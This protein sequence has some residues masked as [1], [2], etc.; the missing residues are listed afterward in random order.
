MGGMG[1]D[2]SVGG[3]SGVGGNGGAVPDPKLCGNSQ[4]DPGEQC[5]D[6]NSI[7]GDGCD[8]DCFFSC[9]PADAS[10]CSD[11]NFCNGPETCNAQHQCQKSAGPAAD[12]TVCG[13]ANRCQGGVCVAAAAVCGDGLIERPQEDC[14]DG[15]T[16][17]GDGCDN[18]RFTCL[19]TDPARNCPTINPCQGNS[20]CNDGTHKCEPI[21][22]TALS[23]GASCGDGKACV[24][25][26]C[27]D[28]YC[29]NG[30]LD[31]GEECDDGNPFKAD[32]CEPNC[33]FSCV[34][35]DPM[36]NC[37]SK[38]ECIASGTCNTTTHKCTPLDPKPAGTACQTSENCVEG[39]CIQPVCGD[40]IKGPNEACDDGNG[41]NTDACTTQCLPVCKA[42]TVATDCMG[43]TPPP[44]RVISCNGGACGTKAD[45]TQNG[46][47]CSF[48]G[49]NGT[50]KDGACSN[51]TCGDHV[52]DPGEQCD[53]GNKV[54]GDGCDT[55]CLFS[56]A[57]DTDCDD[58]NPCNGVEKCTMVGDNKLCKAENP[59]ADGA[60]CAAGKICSGSICRASFCGDGYTDMKKGETCDPPNTLGCDSSCH[61]I[62]TCNITG[63]WA[64]KVAAKV[65]WTGAGLV[66]GMGEIDQ[67]ALMKVVQGNNDTAFTASI[68]PCGITIP[69]FHSIPNFG[70]E[71]YG[72]TFPSSAFDSPK[73]PTFA[74]N[75]KLGNLSPGASFEA[76]TSTIL[77]GLTIGSPASPSGQWP[78]SYM[79]LTAANGF[80][81]TDV[82]ND[83]SPGITA[84]VKTGTIPGTATPYKDIIWDIGNPPLQNPGRTGKLQIVIRQI[85]AENGTLDTCSQLSGTTSAAIDN[86]IVGCV[87]DDKSTTCKPDLLDFARPVYSTTSATFLAYRIGTDDSCGAVRTA[88]P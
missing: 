24:G 21:A 52:L 71:T 20:K 74:F 79:D 12:G 73:I 59:L 70:D 55:D 18:C 58:K 25:G 77:I 13:D 75:G 33:T 54:D 3:M 62:S 84:N 16:V 53:D 76:A 86:H 17:N 6:G 43:K 65:T 45:T 56:C 83:G 11:G 67:W 26:I 9:T 47:S 38:V 57:A 82:D 69:D 1:P 27:T 15:N 34:P 8:K 61:A 42:A 28:K 37:Q 63:N 51:G 68:K 66:D 36:R 22:G 31:A 80:T 23:E 41:S 72:I 30:K 35:T 88:V 64:M 60:D 87:A 85:A 32:G 46:A 39:N 81:V 14:E 29:G 49:Q 4:M 40:G 78:G 2:A 44:C 10:R 7:N 19:T 48:N 50:C 5:D